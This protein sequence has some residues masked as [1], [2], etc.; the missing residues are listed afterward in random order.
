[1]SEKRVRVQSSLFNDVWRGR[2]NDKS[3][4]TINGLENAMKA[5]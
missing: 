5:E 4:A 3:F 1:M 2:F